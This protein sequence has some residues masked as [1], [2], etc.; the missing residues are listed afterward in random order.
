MADL[1]RQATPVL[2]KTGTMRDKD[3]GGNF[4]PT[5]EFESTI[6]FQNV[7]DESNQSIHKI[8][9]HIDKHHFVAFA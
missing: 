9:A 2:T 8:Y 3:Q 7:I 5:Q 4:A 1:T 6:C